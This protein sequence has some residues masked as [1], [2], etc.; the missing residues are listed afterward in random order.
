M[1]LAVTVAANRN[2]LRQ[3]LDELRN[4]AF[5]SLADR[6]LLRA[7]VSMMKLKACFVAFAA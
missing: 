1:S 7:V 2:T 4:A 5:V 6:E 3:F